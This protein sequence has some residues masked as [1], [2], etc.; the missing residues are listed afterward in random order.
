[1][2][3]LV[4]A[5]KTVLAS[6]EV[7]HT[8]AERR[9][10]LIG[11]PNLSGAFVID[12]CRWVHSIGMGFD[13]DVAYVDGAGR[14]RKTSRLKKQRVA[15]PVPSARWVIE[16]EAGA[17]ARW[18]LSVGDMVEVRVDTTCDGNLTTPE[19]HQRLRS[20]HGHQRRAVLAA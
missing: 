16:A 5:D 12:R 14:V 8:R 2:A 20:E 1:M 10:G 18:G 15:L 4:T 3:W 13:L 7:A 6:A 11:R 9:R 17:F 19:S